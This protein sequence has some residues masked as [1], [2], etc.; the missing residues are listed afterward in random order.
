MARGGARTGVVDD[1][2]EARGLGVVAGDD[3]RRY[4]FHATAL[5]DGRRRV[6]VGT[7]VAFAVAAGHRGRLE[8][9]TL[10]A[11]GLGT[12]LTAAGSAAAGRAPAPATPD[13]ASPDPATGRQA[14]PG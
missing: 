1:Y 11:A 12:T 6:A 2:D 13:L 9:R 8:A 5:V 14:G 4:D 7:R 10:T 3:G